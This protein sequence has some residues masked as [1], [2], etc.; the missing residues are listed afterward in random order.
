MRQISLLSLA[1]FC[2][3]PSAGLWAQPVAATTEF[4]AAPGA[5]YAVP[6]DQDD[7]AQS[8]YKQGYN[9]ILDE[10]WSPARKKFTELLQKHPATKYKD[11]AL[12][13]S[14]YALMHTDLRKAL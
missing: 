7:P 10:Q 8:L 14:A 9:L 3:I 1:L 4:L 13:W 6:E 11:D 12:Y 5:P 2:I